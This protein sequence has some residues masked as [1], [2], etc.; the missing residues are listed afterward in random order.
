MSTPEESS[1]GYPEEQPAGA[2]PSGGGGRAEDRPPREG[3]KAPR[4]H[5]DLEDDTDHGKATGNPRS[6]G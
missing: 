1:Q 6:A 2:D 5:D 4:K 3:A